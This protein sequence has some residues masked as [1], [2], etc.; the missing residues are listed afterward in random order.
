MCFTCV[1]SP[2]P[3]PF[4]FVSLSLTGFLLLF[5]SPSSLACVFLL[6]ASVLFFYPSVFLFMD[7]AFPFCENFTL[8]KRNFIL[9]ILAPDFSGSTCSL[10]F[11]FYNFTLWISCLFFFPTNL[12]LRRTKDN[13]VCCCFFKTFLW[14]KIWIFLKFVSIAFVLGS[15][16]ACFGQFQIIWQQIG[17]SLL[18]ELTKT[19]L[20]NSSR[21]NSIIFHQYSSHAI[22]LWV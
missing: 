7:F 6:A 4:V 13:C 9:P 19:R 15:C 8:I 2:P 10:S 5:P 21:I 17:F 22:I 12:K 20:I 14:T 3:P 16:A 1:Q 18:C 11:P